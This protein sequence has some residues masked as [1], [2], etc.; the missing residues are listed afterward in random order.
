MRE[1]RRLRRQDF[2]GPF[3]V[4]WRRCG[5]ASARGQ[6][7]QEEGGGGHEVEH[8]V[9]AEACHEARTDERANH[10]AEPTNQN[11]LAAYRHDPVG[12]HVIVRVSDADRVKGRHK[13][14]E[15]GRGR[16]NDRQGVR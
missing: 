15:Q 16:Q 2:E 7:G 8:A 11:E 14:A 4:L 10:R 1:R 9:D 12:R 5:Q 6:E 13:A 3:S